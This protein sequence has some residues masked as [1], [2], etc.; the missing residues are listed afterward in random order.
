[1]M[2][3]IL[4]Y[5]WVL[6]GWFFNHPLKT[7]IKWSFEWMIEKSSTQNE[8]Y[9]WILLKIHECESNMA[10]KKYWKI[11]LVVMVSLEKYWICH[12]WLVINSIFFLMI[13]ITTCD[14]FQYFFPAMHDSYIQTRYTYSNLGKQFC[15]ISFDEIH[16]EMIM[17]DLTNYCP[18]FSFLRVYI[19]LMQF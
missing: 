17:P 9:F 11:S 14:I 10:V 3:E 2:C 18:H 13:I 15:E 8:K 12:S 6:S 7:P 19:I 16:L 1:M 4:L 5:I